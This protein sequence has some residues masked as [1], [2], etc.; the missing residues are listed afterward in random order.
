M[1]NTLVKFAQ[2]LAEALRVNFLLRSKALIYE[3][4]RRIPAC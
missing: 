2:V 1:Y 3:V 4:V